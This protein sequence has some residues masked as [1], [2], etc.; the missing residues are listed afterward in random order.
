MQIGNA[1]GVDIDTSACSSS[2]MALKRI[3]DKSLGIP[4]SAYKRLYNIFLRVVQGCWIMN[5]KL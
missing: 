3:E 2:L 4:W 1:Q 5:I